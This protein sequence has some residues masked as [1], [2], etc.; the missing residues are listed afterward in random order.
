MQ[1]LVIAAALLRI[2]QYGVSKV[3]LCQACACIGRY[4]P[5]VRMVVLSQ[6][7]VRGPDHQGARVGADFQYFVMCSTGIHDA[8]YDFGD[9]YSACV[10]A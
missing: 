8:I 9:Q 3:D 4:R 1:H 5:F 7:T 6:I 2:G 10:F